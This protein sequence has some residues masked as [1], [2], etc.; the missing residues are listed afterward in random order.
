MFDDQSKKFKNQFV[1]QGPIDVNEYEEFVGKDKINELEKLAVDLQNKSWINVNSTCVGGGV[2]EMLYSVVPFAKG[3]GINCK[4]YVIEGEEDFF[5]VTKKFHNLLQGVKTT[6]NLK[7]IF[8]AYLET[9][10]HNL[11]DKEI[12]GDMVVVHDPQPA[13]AIMSG[14]VFGNILWRC[15]I[16]TTDADLFI[17]RF[18]LPYIN[19]YDGAIFT[20]NEFVKH[21]VNI[22]IYEISPC[23]DPLKEKNKSR[24]EEQSLKILEPLLKKHKI[25][26]ERPIVLAVSRY[27]I[28]KN[29]KTII[30]AFKL[31]KNDKEV[32]RLNPILIIVGNSAIDDPEGQKIYEQVLKEIDNDKNIYPLLNIKNNDKNI[33]ALMRIAK[34]FVH[35]STKEGFGLVVTEA[36]WQST[37]VI[38]SN[39]GGIKKQVNEGVNGFIVEPNETEKI[40]NHIKT[41]LTK[42]DERETMAKNAVEHVRK[43]FLLPG[44]LKKYLLLMRYY[45]EIDLSLP[46]F[47]LNE[48]TYKEIKNAVYNRSSWHFSVSDLKRKIENKLFE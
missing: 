41:L 37:P 16:D 4:W 43:N 25:D 38:G 15:H 32:K 7:E 39:I 28:H 13:A 26:A 19:H 22:P 31:A 5:T 42:K 34:C 6:I 29:Q 10:E 8:H 36:M 40:A 3:L 17:W 48:L 46:D 2:A 21:G 27:D 44:L 30:K 18:L 11:K 47:R 33:G 45:L 9:I 35:I 14:N 12:F 23:I 20:C 1:I 24:S